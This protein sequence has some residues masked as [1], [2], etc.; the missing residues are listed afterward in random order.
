[1]EKDFDQWNLEKKRAEYSKDDSFWV[2]E[3]EI[4]WCRFGLNI[5][6]EI[7]GKNHMFERPAL[8]I[9][10]FNDQMFWILPLKHSTSTNRFCH[11]LQGAEESQVVLSQIRTVSF[12]R[13]VRKMGDV[14]REELALIKEKVKALL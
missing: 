4:W 3:G 8:V 2:L 1:M 11:K 10:K 14:E 7:D 12:K 9:R 6:V 13:L 5:G